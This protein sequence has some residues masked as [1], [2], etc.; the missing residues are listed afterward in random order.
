M[1]D[2]SDRQAFLS[3]R[4]ISRAADGTRETSQKT[5][6]ALTKIHR[7]SLFGQIKALFVLFRP[8]LPNEALLRPR[9]SKS[10]I[11]IETTVRKFALV[12]SKTHRFIF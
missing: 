9:K 11:A 4:R 7:L 8:H 6:T 2:R 10:R 3:E 5:L 1:N 12:G